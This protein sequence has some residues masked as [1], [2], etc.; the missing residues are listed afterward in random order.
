MPELPEPNSPRHQEPSDSDRK[1]QSELEQ[2]P[3]ARDFGFV[4]VQAT[5]RR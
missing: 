5:I 4:P 2:S 3:A 1:Q